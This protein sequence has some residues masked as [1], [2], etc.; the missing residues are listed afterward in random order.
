LESVG[1]GVGGLVICFLRGVPEGAVEAIG[2][3]SGGQ[4]GAIFGDF[5]ALTRTF[6]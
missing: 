2:A 5:F 4:I 3:V 1:V 6:C